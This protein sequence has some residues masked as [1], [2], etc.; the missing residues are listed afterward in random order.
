MPAIAMLLGLLCVLGA[1]AD[2]TNVWLERRDARKARAPALVSRL[3]M[4]KPDVG[5]AKVPVQVWVLAV[6]A[7]IVTELWTHQIVLAIGGGAVLYMTRLFFGTDPMEGRL[8]SM[9]S[10]IAWMQNLTYLLQT[11]KTAWESLMMSAKALP[12]DAAAELQ[13]S[14]QQSN[15]QI[16]GYVIRLRDALTLFAIR[17]A[18]PQVDVVVALVNA[19]LASSGGAYDYHVMAKIQD[20]LKSELIEH[21]AAISARR[22]IF[23]IAKIL[24]PAVVVM[25]TLLA[26]MMGNFVLPFYMTP[27]GYAVALAVEAMTVALLLL[28]RRFSA[29]LP[30]TR[31]IVPQTF[32]EVLGR[33]VD[34]SASASQPAEQGTEK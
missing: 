28:F 24:F 32:L 25:E 9:E 6:L 11:S 15:A 19:N 8:A 22:E 29:P 2:L 7:A 18:D 14:L 34:R 5:A 21:N 1:L 3:A 20:Q 16:G 33:H 17:R 27:A 26:A 12:D 31:L 23:T 10:N 30:E 4:V 13:A